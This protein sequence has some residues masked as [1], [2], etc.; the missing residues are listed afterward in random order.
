[1]GEFLFGQAVE[2]GDQGVELG[3]EFGALGWIGYAVLV[4]F[5]ADLLGQSVKF[6]RGADQAGGAFHDGRELRVFSRQTGDGK[7]VDVG[8]IY[9]RRNA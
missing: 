6:R 5:Q 8:E 4:A 7:L 9:V 1:M 2:V 3:A